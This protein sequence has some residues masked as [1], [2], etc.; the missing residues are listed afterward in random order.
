MEEWRVIPKHPKYEISNLGR[1]RRKN[2]HYYPQWPSQP[3]PE[4]RYYKGSYRGG[5]IRLF[6]GRGKKTITYAHAVLEAF[7]G[8]RPVGMQCDH[9]NRIKD[10]NRLVNLR[11]VTCSDNQRNRVYSPEEMAKRSQRLSKLMK[12]RNQTRDPKTGRFIKST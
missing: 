10:D 9:I 5:Y 11:W 4:Y 8:P 7:V 2:K 1:M 6:R 3:T 12:N